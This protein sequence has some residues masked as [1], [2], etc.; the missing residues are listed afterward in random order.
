MVQKNSQKNAG[1]KEPSQSNRN[2]VKS[3]TWWRYFFYNSLSGENFFKPRYGLFAVYRNPARRARP[4]TAADSKWKRAP[5]C[6]GADN[7]IIF[8][9]WP[10]GYCAFHT[11]AFLISHYI[12]IRISQRA[13]AS[14]KSWL[15]RTSFFTRIRHSITVIQI[16]AVD[17]TIKYIPHTLEPKGLRF[18]VLSI[19]KYRKNTESTANARIRC[20]NWYRLRESN[21]WFSRERAASWPLDQGDTFSFVRL[22]NWRILLYTVNWLL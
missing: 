21:P 11:S 1:R 2:A 17:K 12:S 20:F 10:L 15:M 19:R 14:T 8:C 18:E 22:E 3:W 16:K 4:A 6:R 7:P 13:L 9:H 5:V